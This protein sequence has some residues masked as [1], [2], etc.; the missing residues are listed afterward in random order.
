VLRPSKRKWTLF[1]LA[2]VGFVAGALMML[3][4]P[5]TDRF[6]AYLCIFFFGGCAVCF[7]LLLV[8]GSSFL[9]LDPEGLTVRTM[10]RT[11]SYRWSDIE[12]FGVGEFST[13]HGF[14]RQRHQLIGYDFSANYRDFDQGRRLKEMNRGLIGFEASL[15][16]NYG[17]EYAELAE[18]LNTL[19]ER[20]EN[21]R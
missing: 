17:W 13:T 11:Q 7:L 15:P 9:R 18:H 12:R 19:K 6:M 3:R 16:D 10:W 1:F 20:H 21:R 2:S 5:G 14:L 8:P 4:D